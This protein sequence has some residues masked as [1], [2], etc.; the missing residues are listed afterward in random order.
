MTGYQEI[1]TGEFISLEDSYIYA[2]KQLQSNPKLQ[3]EFVN[4]GY[5]PDQ[6]EDVV[7]FIFS[8]NYVEK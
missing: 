3:A 1:N 2:L 7:E 4:F 8:G 6:S 5:D